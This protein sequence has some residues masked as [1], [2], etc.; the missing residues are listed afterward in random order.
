[1]ISII[2]PTYN[3]GAYLEKCIQSIVNQE[4]DDYEHIIVDGGSTDNTLAII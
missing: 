3:S 4:F 1:M 2:T